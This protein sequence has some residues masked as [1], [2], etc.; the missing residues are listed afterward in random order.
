MK[1]RY[2]FVSNSSSTSY[3][4]Q[5]CHDTISGWDSTL[6]FRDAGLFQCRNYHIIHTKCCID[7]EEKWKQQPCLNCDGTKIICGA[8]PFE[9]DA[10]KNE[11]IDFCRCW[12]E[13]ETCKY[14]TECPDCKDGMVKLPDTDSE[15]W[16]QFAHPSLCSICNLEV[17]PDNLE[18]AFLRKSL[19]LSKEKTL[20]TIRHQFNSLQE[21]HAYLGGDNEYDWGE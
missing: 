7:F 1:L 12:D 21:I 20:E 6:Q 2:G 14:P 16:R 10:E 9:W 4:C 17:L 5:V 11:P 19:K 15:D 18:L 13:N 8:P 3:T